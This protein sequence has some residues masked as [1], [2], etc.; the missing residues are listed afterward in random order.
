MAGRPRLAIGTHGDIHVKRMAPRRYR[1]RCRVR[2]ADGKVREAKATS[3]SRNQA[4]AVLRERLKERLGF[5]ASGL[6]SLSSPF[7]DLANL[8]LQE[9]A[10]R[11]IANNTK[12]NYRDDLRVHVMPFFEAY[13]LGEIT[14]GRVETFLQQQYAVSYSMAKHSRTLLNQLFKFAIRNDGMVR[15]PVEATS[16]LAKPKG[17]PQALTPEQILA[18]RK[19][20][21][22]WRTGPGV[23]GPKP[24]GNVRDALEVM[25]GTGMRPGEALAFRPVDVRD[26]KSGMVIEICGTLVYEQG[27]GTFR[28]DHPKTHA[29][30]RRI[31]VAG[32]AAEVIRRRLEEMGPGDQ[33]D[34]VFHNRRGGVLSMYNFRRTFRAFLELADL[35]DSGISPRWYRRTVATIIARAHGLDAAATHLGHTSSAI[36][37]GFY[38]EPDVTVRHEVML[39]VQATGRAEAPDFSVLLQGLDEEQEDVLD[40]LEENEPEDGSTAE[41]DAA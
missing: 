14:T 13:T 31:P 20:A 36:T 4:K 35:Q 19:A 1:A 28:Q 12:E 39:A 37:A 18:I 32:F 25:L 27:K 16:P 23:K 8:W 17:K 21:N 15:N 6:L 9:L 40:R 10:G 24:D 22:E 38:V 33:E 2:D 11:D 34:T 29:S 5:G 3:R 26:T 30:R 41:A 7:P